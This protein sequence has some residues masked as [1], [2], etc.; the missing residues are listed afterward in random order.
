MNA[1]EKRSLDYIKS[2]Y[3]NRTVRMVRDG[4]FEIESGPDHYGDTFFYRVAYIGNRG[5]GKNCLVDCTGDEDKIMK[6]MGEQ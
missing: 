3:N 1:I 2:I 4:D 6:Y 5:E